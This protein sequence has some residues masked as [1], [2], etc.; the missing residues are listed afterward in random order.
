MRVDSLA[1]RI[2]PAPGAPVAVLWARGALTS[3]IAT[4]D[5]LELVA[6]STHIVARGRIPLGGGAGALV[7]NLDC[8]LEATPFDAALLR[9]WVSIPPA[10]ASATA[11]VHAHLRGESWA[12]VKGD[13]RIEIEPGR[14]GTRR[15]PPVLLE[16]HAEDGR[17]VLAGHIDDASHPIRLDLQARGAETPIPIQLQLEHPGGRLALAGTIAPQADGP[18]SLTEGRI[19]GL[20]LSQWKAGAP[21]SALT[22]TFTAQG[23]GRTLPQLD[24]RAALHF[25]A[26][27][28]D[29]LAIDAADLDA[30]VHAGTL[31]LAISG[32]AQ[33]ARMQVDATAELLAS[34]R[35]GT[36][37]VRFDGVDLARWAAGAPPTAL[38]GD[39]GGS[40]ELPAAGSPSAAAHLVLRPSRCGSQAIDGLDL[41]LDWQD[42]A[43]ALHGTSR[44]PT[45]R[46]A[47]D[48]TARPA[49]VPPQ[50]ELRTL[51]F[52]GIDVGA[53]LARPS[54]QSHLQGNASGRVALGTATARTWDAQ[55]DLGASTLRNLRIESL[56]AESSGRGTA[57][58][59]QGDVR[60]PG[61]T[62]VV[63]AHAEPGDG[64]P[65]WN[66]HGELR[67]ESL[68]RFVGRD[69][70]PG[71]ARLAFTAT[72]AG[73]DRPHLQL[74][75]RVEGEA[76][77]QD[78]RLD[79]LLAT[80]RIAAD[81][82]H[83][84]TLA[85][86]SNV[87]HATGGGTVGLGDFL[88]PPGHPLT[89]AGRVD[90]LAP[91]ATLLG[92][93]TLGARNAGFAAS[94]ART[95]DTGALQATVTAD[96]LRSGD[97]R[98]QHAEARA[99]AA[100]LPGLVLGQAHVTAAVDSLR[101]GTF[102]AAQTR[103]TAVSDSAGMQLSAH[104]IL[105]DSTAVRLAA[106]GTP[107]Y[108]GEAVLDTLA[109]Q[110]GDD[111]W[112]LE[113]PVRIQYG[114]RFAVDDFR[115]VAGDQRVFVSG[116]YDANGLH[117]LE[118]RI[119]SLQLS[120][121]ASRCG[122][123][124][125][126]G[127]AT[128]LVHTVSADSAP[129]L[130]GNARLTLSRQGEELGLGGDFVHDAA[131]VKLQV[132]VAD[133]KGDS[134]RVRGQIPIALPRLGIV[135]P[136]LVKSAPLALDL[137]ADAFRIEPLRMLLPR[138]SIDR[139]EGALW[140]NAHVS[141]TVGAPRMQ[142]SLRLEQGVV[143]SQATGSTYKDIAVRITLAGDSLR[144]DELVVSAG[145][146][147]MR[148]TGSVQFAPGGVRNLD[149]DAKLDRFRALGR[150]Q[151][152]VEASGDL[153]VAGSPAAPEIR[154]NLRLDDST[155]DV[156]DLAPSSADV[157]LTEADLRMLE[158]NFGSRFRPT[159][160]SGT[161]A[162]DPVALDVQVSTPR[163]TWLKRRSMP[164][165]QIE[166]KGGVQVHKEPQKP[167]EVR[168]RIEA[169]PTRSY[170][171]QLGRRFELEKGLVVF[172]G[173][174]SK[175]TVDLMAKYEIA[176]TR[177]SND[178]AA[179]IHASVR[180]PF[181]DLR[182]TWTSEPARDES[183]IVTALV[184][185]R[186]FEATTPDAEATAGAGTAIAVGQAAGM[187]E[188]LGSGIGLDVLQIQMDGVRGATIVAGRYMNPKTYVGLR[189]ATT[190]ESQPTDASTTGSNSEVEL[191]YKLLDWLVLN[192][193]GGVSDVRAMLGSRYEY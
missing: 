149:L 168:G 135:T 152:S 19:E 129:R 60:I 133:G 62:G 32:G 74:A 145:R 150:R 4:L 57:I 146:G 123:T 66:T 130:D 26:S 192:L 162:F 171:E 25:E 181:D 91:L 14:W 1:A 180:G 85:V 177:D 156:T 107:R 185:G 103:A 79:S 169:L 128:V 113:H 88:P 86:R 38:D 5:S 53:W 97:V 174:P 11:H 141:G 28:F 178:P 165:L 96:S 64:V 138:R 29:S 9:P 35:N 163:D 126:G 119:D 6:D 110:L 70:V 182:L 51:E 59:L 105:D 18:W 170:V 65:Q 7:R 159:R 136:A 31:Q 144:L 143:A 108:P 82:V 167:I 101:A 77:L 71:S 102:F 34:P 3:E 99:E 2:S 98:I 56:H 173:D 124:G 109:V 43:L 84:D 48:G 115:L 45:G 95:G 122:W 12:Q 68:G 166:L 73:F 190:F 132:F 184:T 10:G 41:Q 89:L 47:L 139:L 116:S 140:V 21:V 120:P 83:V 72:G 153:Q 187:M 176:S 55:L 164:R 78:L 69:S 17:I 161:S 188:D 44:F 16:S 39:L 157:Q 179:V 58:A 40:F 111:A 50:Y 131:G 23:R 24:A 155:I 61:G 154:G 137:Q 127:R 142:G 94:L 121:I 148:S 151:L 52:E 93:G 92:L 76:V 112:Q 193:Q 175:G 8:D 186:G 160:A 75:G 20:D 13:L 87:L 191:E 80:V 189:Q 117:D 42:G 125:Y 114:P 134:L 67:T 172:D 49:A 104:S 147:H 118:A 63:E 100:L 33:G 183:D 30:R 22:A 37:R 15:T 46:L 54:L 158:E 36:A 81:T 90:D 27:R 106:R